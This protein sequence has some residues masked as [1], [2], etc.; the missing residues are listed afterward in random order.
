MVSVVYFRLFSKR[1]F[2]VDG[3]LFLITCFHLSGISLAWLRP[4]FSVM[5]ASLPLAAT[6]TFSR[7]VPQGFTRLEVVYSF[8]CFW[9]LSHRIF[10]GGI[11]LSKEKR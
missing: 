9:Q 2:K 4:C 8:I 7:R 5:F 10:W 11:P 3:Q 1:H 6:A